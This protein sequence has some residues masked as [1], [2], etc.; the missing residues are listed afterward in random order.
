MTETIH[1]L[2]EKFAIKDIARFETGE[3]GLA[4][5]SITTDQGEATLYHYGAHV[6]HFRPQGEQPLLWMSSKSHFQAGKAIRGGVPLVFPWFG[7]RKDDPEAPSHGLVRTAPWSVETLDQLQDGSVRI[8]LGI[9]VESF[10][11]LY[12]V[13][14]GRRLGLEMVVTNTSDQSVMFEQAMHTYL[15][16]AD[17][18]Q[19]SVSGL[20]GTTYIDKV[21]DLLRKP[22]PDTP[23]RFTRETDSVY[24]DTEATVHV[25]DTKRD[26]SIIVEKTGSQSTVVWNPWTDKAK[27]MP[28]FGDTEWPGMVCIETANVADN[29]IHL[30]A[31]DSTAMGTTLG[32]ATVQK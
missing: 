9:S 24:L 30:A 7:P 26:R 15:S 19:T 14:V 32:I 1:T 20:S 6:T 3:G 27:R 2:N 11:I 5:L 25:E 16:V 22:Q 17:I 4:R 28:D 13:T 12:H 8:S 23:I 18:H 31:G 21:D 29:S 10:K